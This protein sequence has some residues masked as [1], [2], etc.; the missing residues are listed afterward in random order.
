MACM[1][2]MIRLWLHTVLSDTGMMDED[3]RCYY[4]HFRFVLVDVMGV[5]GMV[6]SRLIIVQGR[7]V[8]EGEA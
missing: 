5:I 2:V 7:E 6:V 1:V 3:L 4:I 8:Q